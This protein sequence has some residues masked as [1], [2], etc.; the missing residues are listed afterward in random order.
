MSL[1]KAKKVGTVKISQ[2][3]LYLPPRRMR[4]VTP[5][6]CRQKQPI[7]GILHYFR[8]GHNVVFPLI[9]DTVYRNVAGFVDAA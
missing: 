1:E 3:L 4:G 9:L 2:A 8:A 5:T 6:R 7:I